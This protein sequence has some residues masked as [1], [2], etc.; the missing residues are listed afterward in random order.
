MK[1]HKKRGI[2]IILIITFLQVVISPLRAVAKRPDVDVSQ[3]LPVEIDAMPFRDSR[4]KIHYEQLPEGAYE[5]N[6]HLYVPAGSSKGLPV[7]EKVIEKVIT[8]PNGNEYEAV[9]D[10]RAEEVARMEFLRLQEEEELEKERLELEEERKAFIAPFQSKENW[11]VSPFKLELDIL[12]ITQANEAKKNKD[13]IKPVT[14]ESPV[15]YNQKT[16][17]LVNCGTIIPATLLTGLNSDLPGHLIAQVSEPVCDTSTGKKILIPQ[18]ARLFGEYS[19][20]VIFGQKRP[21]VRWTK[22]IMP[23]GSTIDLQN[24]AGYDKK[25]YAGFKANVNNHYF[26]MFASAAM[27]SLFAWGVD[28]LETE[29]T[30][31]TINNPTLSIGDEVPVGSISLWATNTAPSGYLLCDG[32]EFD[33][34]AFPT[35]HELLPDDHAPIMPQEAGKYYIIKAR[36]RGLTTSI[37]GSVVGSQTINTS[38]NSSFKAEIAKSLNI[39]ENIVQLILEVGTDS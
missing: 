1:E 8:T 22:V 34:V 39:E 35:L 38:S 15:I 16:Y 5:E 18:G 7:I 27:I 6:G 32:Q 29:D 26:P 13:Y 19:S 9:T 33:P 36:G 4:G 24:M 20:Q 14:W 2:S 31:V 10:E 28:K 23:D 3:Y 17:G 21:M 37:L 11:Q 12:P 30:Q 25:G